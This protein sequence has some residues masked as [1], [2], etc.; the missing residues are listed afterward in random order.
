MDI[1]LFI[2]LLLVAIL[3]LLTA[4]FV[5]A[6][7]AVV[8]VRLSRLDQ[9]IAEGNKKAV[10]AKKVAEKLDYY[11][12]ACQL[13]ITVTALGLGWLGKPTVERIL[14]P[15]FDNL[16][17]SQALAAVVSFVIAFSIVT[18]LHVVIGELA[19]KTLAIQFAEKVSLL[20]AP[21]LY[22]FGKI[23]F[24]FIWSLNGSARV[25]LRLFGVKPSTEEQAHSEEELKIILSQS[26][27]SGE[28]N[29]SELDY[30]ERIFTFDEREAKDVMIPRTEMITLTP[31]MTE[32]EVMK[33]I[34]HY[35]HTRYP[36]TE[37]GDKDKIIGY[38]NVKKLLMGYIGNQKA[39]LIDYM[40][41]IPSL[42]EH[43]RIQ[44][45]FMKMKSS[46]VHL[47]LLL[48]EYGGTAGMITMEDILEEIVGEIQDEFDMDEVEDIKKVDEQTFHING[49]TLISEV[50]EKLGIEFEEEVDTIGG[51]V[52]MHRINE[53]S[54]AE[55]LSN[56]NRWTILEMDHLQIKRVAVELSAE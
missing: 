52:Q 34:N 41:S 48:D 32:D 17:I 11:L 35:Q 27:Q 20:L 47:I 22:W 13:G 33:V 16:E 50:E 53:E 26:Y 10:K 36:V 5:G 19:P 54:N 14:Y 31:E 1:I 3:I 56:G 49:K 55:L 25:F 42:P 44:Q 4:F 29:Q 40:Q 18:F 23:M 24:P 37:N 21:P 51:W 9:L 38:I 2:N 8:K 7:F 30:M 12:S 43:T 6:E 28:I 46:R 39:K 45:V 15:V